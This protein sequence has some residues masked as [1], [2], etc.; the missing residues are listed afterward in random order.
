MRRGRYEFAALPITVVLLAALFAVF[1][2]SRLGAWAWILAGVCIAG[3]SALLIWRLAGSS[4]GEVGEPPP[5]RA[6]RAGPVHRVLLVTVAGRPATGIEE[7][8]TAGAGGRPT[9]AFVVVPTR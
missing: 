1:G 4:W 3:G 8:V 5:A 9:E 7:L 6:A 2:A